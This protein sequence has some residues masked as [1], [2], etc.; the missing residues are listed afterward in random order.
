MEKEIKMKKKFQ[1][2]KKFQ[3]ERMKRKQK[4]RDKGM[5]NTCLG[6]MFN[7]TR[8]YAKHRCWWQEAEI[9]TAVVS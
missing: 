4:K 2:R 8:K 3:I 1:L 7:C 5:I 9:N 6:Y